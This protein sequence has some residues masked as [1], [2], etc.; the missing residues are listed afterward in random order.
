MEDC[1][2]LL[3]GSKDYPE[4]SWADWLKNQQFPDYLAS[5]YC[6]EYEEYH[7]EKDQAQPIDWNN[8]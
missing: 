5:L 3:E 7:F 6:Q 4:Y 8:K 2:N 1:R